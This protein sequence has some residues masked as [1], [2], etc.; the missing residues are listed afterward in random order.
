VVAHQLVTAGP[1]RTRAQRAD[2]RHDRA[3]ARRERA[4]RRA[5][6]KRATAVLDTDGKV[7]LVHAPGRVAMARKRGRARLETVPP[8]PVWL[9]WPMVLPGSLEPAASLLADVQADEAVAA[10]RG[11][12]TTFMPAPSGAP[13]DRPRPRLAPAPD[14]EV[15]QEQR[16]TEKPAE[17]QEERAK[18]GPASAPNRAPRQAARKRQNGAPTAAAKRAKAEELARANPGISR[19]ELVEQSGVSERT[20]DRIRAAANRAGKV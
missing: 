16:A 5:A 12:R 6:L 8:E 2:A 10:Y 18:P 17:A 14:P 11:W 19:A 20:A 4:I 13:Q 7:R 9:P 3:A 1:R 15:A